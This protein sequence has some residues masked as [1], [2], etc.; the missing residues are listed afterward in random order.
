MKVYHVIQIKF[1]RLVQDNIHVIIDLPTKP[2]E[3]TAE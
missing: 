3:V 2:I 1:N